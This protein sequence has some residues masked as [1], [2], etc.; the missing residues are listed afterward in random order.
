VSSVGYLTALTG[1]EAVRGILC[2]LWDI[3]L[4]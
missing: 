2:L 1:V 4:R 3:S